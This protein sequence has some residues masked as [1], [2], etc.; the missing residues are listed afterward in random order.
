MNTTPSPLSKRPQ[1]A[2]SDAATAFINARI[3]DPATDRDEAGGLIVRNG[4]IED[5]GPHLRR[6]APEGATVVDCKGHV[7]APGLIDA[8]VFA[9]EPGFEHRETLKTASHA[10]AA[11]G[12]TTMVV[13]PDTNPVI[14]QVALVDFIQ[15]R[16]RDNAIV[17][18]HTM[19]AMTK[20]LNGEEMTEIGLLKRAG[21]IAFS[22]GKRSIANTRVMRNVLL[23]SRD[24]GALIVHHTED[25]YLSATG[26]MNSG[27]V[28][29]R[30]GLSGIPRASETIILERDVRLVEMTSGRYH[31][32]TISTADSLAVVRAA[33]SK[34]LPVTCG[35]TI[36]HLTLNENDIGPY[37][38][39]FKMRPPLRADA[40]RAA[41]VEG[42]ASGD[43]DIIVSSHDP[44]DADDKRRPFAE[45]TDGAVGLETLLPAALRLHHSGELPLM[46]I[47]RALT[48]NP[49]KLLGLHS[50]RLAK[51]SIADLII[52]DPDE[53]WVL[54]KDQLRSR[55]KNSPFDESKM[56]GRVMRTVVA[57]ETVYQR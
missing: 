21:A 12:V 1:R 17:H 48:I 16:A 26:S 32:A 3:I 40:D 9:G 13:M 51:G 35:V 57:G 42:L 25:P 56:Q 53:P 5:L 4:L 34:R 20:G 49:A 55:S 39:F 41:M 10:A 37:R 23:Y 28:A 18:V 29:T 11:G 46:T 47:L 50:G 31:A 7:L 44:Q 45:A 33:K 36:N 43:I 27:E 24:F 2:H 38:T 6:N 19:A 52:F 15:R 14:D 8:Q 30:L 22:N 54:N